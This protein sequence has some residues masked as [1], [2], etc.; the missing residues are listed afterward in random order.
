MCFNPLWGFLISS[1]ETYFFK[2]DFFCL[3]NCHVL[4]GDFVE[5]GLALFLGCYSLLCV[6]TVLNAV[7]FSVGLKF[8]SLSVFG[9]N[10]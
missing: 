4:L 1:V 10:V 8:L 2:R 7:C 6:F 9:L 5:A 3:L